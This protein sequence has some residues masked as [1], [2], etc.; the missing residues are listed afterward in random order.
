MTAHSLNKET[1]MTRQ[2]NDTVPDHLI[3]FAEDLAD[4]SR[5]L[6]RSRFRQGPE[7]TMKPDDT[8][9]TPTDHEVEALI[10]RMIAEHHPDHGVIGEEH[11]DSATGAE[12]VWVIDP[13]DGTRAFISGRPVFGT[14]IALTRNGVPILGV[15]DIPVMQERWVGATGHATRL[16]GAIAR[17]RPC[18]QM[19]GAILLACSPEYLDG[20]AAAPFARLVAGTRFTVYDVGTQG[21]GLI[22]SGHADIMVAATYGIVDYLAAAPVIEGA[23]GVMRDWTGAPMTLQSPDRF[24]ALGDPARLDGVLSL[25]EQA[26]PE[27]RTHAESA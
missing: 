15:V 27:G 8:P 9:V 21:Y 17:T 13:I 22:A 3:R 10:R 14:N 20:T 23:G 25:L 26:E 12:H 5:A 16:N 11:P 7:I 4:A 2:P 6:I 24:V 1:S 18:P 19:A